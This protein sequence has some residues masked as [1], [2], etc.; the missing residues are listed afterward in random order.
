MFNHLHK[1]KL[2]NKF[3]SGFLPG[4][5]TTHQLLGIYHTILT[6]LDSNLFTSIIFADGSKALDRVWIRKK[7][8]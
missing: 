3:Q 7:G 4:L 6:A 1:N 2:L 5:S 8:G